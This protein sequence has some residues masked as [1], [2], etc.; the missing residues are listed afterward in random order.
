M[1]KFAVEANKAARA[2][3]TTTNEYAKAS[4][5]FFQ[6][7]DVKEDAMAKANIVSKMANVTG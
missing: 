5:I 7:G 2:L 4:L 6:Q 1:A 3:S